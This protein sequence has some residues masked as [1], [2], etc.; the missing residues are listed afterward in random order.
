MLFESVSGKFLAPDG[1][2]LSGSV[3]FT[4]AF[5]FA[6]DTQAVT[7]PA[8]VT[9][10]LDAEGR[11]TASLQVPD[12]STQPTT[13]TWKACPRLRHAGG[14]VGL[15]PFDFELVQGRPVNLAEV[16]PAP[17]PMTGEYIARGKPGADG[18]GLAAITT[19]GGELVFTLTDGSES[20]I[21]VPQGE[22]GEPGP[23]G[24]PGPMGQVGPAGPKGEQ[25]EIGPA[26]PVGPAGPPGPQGPAG[27][28]G[29]VGPKGEQGESI[30]GPP[31]PAGP[32]GD[33]GPVGPEGPAGPQGNPGPQGDAGPVGPKG[34]PGNPAALVLVGAGRPDDASTLSP[35]N[36]T[37]VADAPVGAT[38]TST[39]GAGTGVWAWVKTP[40]GWRV[41]YGDTGMRNLTRMASFPTPPTNMNI[42]IRR[43]GN[44]VTLW[45][46]ALPHS[47]KGS[48][49]DPIQGFRQAYTR[50]AVGFPAVSDS[51]DKLIGKLQIATVWEWKAAT[52]STELSYVTATWQT[53]DP[54]PA[55]L[56]GT[57]A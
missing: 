55:T 14:A 37:A 48:M 19:E 15:A 17:A 32:Q 31:G 6:R 46:Y 7:L 13:W 54:W 35:E 25:G 56:P 18:V 36:Q 41:A 45:A 40:Q 43:V 16:L 30:V 44:T 29:A 4:P 57:T 38:F 52:G 12:A 9:V 42:N 3:V 26:G 53:S 28:D 51:G 20:R 22:P 50:N 10:Q 11:V 5:S 33:P 2:P 39:N 21:P 24:E 23:A 34:E 49:M 27:K 8:P 47:Y 1:T